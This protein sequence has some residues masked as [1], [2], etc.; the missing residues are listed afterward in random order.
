M[1]S[2]LALVM[3]LLIAALIV[4]PLASWGWGVNGDRLIVNKALDT[5]PADIQQYFEANR[6]FLV[7]HVSDPLDQLTKTPTDKR[8]HFIRLDHYG[9]LPFST[10]PRDYRTAV[11]K[12]GKHN[13]EM[14]G[15]LPWQIGVSSVRLTGAFRAHNWDE[16]RQAAAELAYY[17]AA[18]HDPFNTTMNDDGK[19]SGQ[20]GVNQRFGISLVD[21]YS[22]FFYVR[23]NEASYIRDPTDYAFE[24]C[25][26]AHSWLEN[27]LLSDRRARQGLADYTDEF[28]DRFYSQAGAV[29]IR[30]ISDAST[31]VGSYWL[32]AWTNAGR[33]QL[34]T[35]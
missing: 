13:L 17:V 27:I 31:D 32:T 12:F 4:V 1:R 2:R 6:N 23:P 21:R 25:L 19:L 33:P 8:N 28:Y 14:Y 20:P 24:M 22:L 10:L 3:A 5:L 35:R 26:N 18:A 7:R 30:E 29:L 16:A 11:F 15:L 34:P 9:Q